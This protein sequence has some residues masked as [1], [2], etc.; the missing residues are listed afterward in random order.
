MDTDFGACILQIE[1]SKN[2]SLKLKKPTVQAEGEQ[3]SQVWEMFFD[4]AC[5]RDTARAGVVLVSPEK[6]ITELCFKLAFQVKNNITECEALLLGLNATK[7]KG[8]KSIKVFGDA[9]LV[10]QQ[11]NKTFQARHPRLK[12]YRDEVWRIRDSFDYFCISY[13][14]RAQN[15]LVD[16]LAV[17]ASL[18]IPPSPPKL[19]Y[20][21]QIKYRPSVPD[22]VHHWKVFDDD[23]ELNRFLQF[24]DEFSE[25]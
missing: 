16:S 8:I 15:Q 3:G 10:I 9:D 22:N 20:E 2:A 21:V 6:E 5:S 25:M 11:V 17:S 19:V 24:S 4:G 13:I 1:E 12:A 7:Y 14:P 18:F 23:D